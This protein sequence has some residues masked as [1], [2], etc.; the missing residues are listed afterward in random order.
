MKGLL[1]EILY[2]S[3]IHLLQILF[4]HQF[5]ISHNRSLPFLITVVPEISIRRSRPWSISSVQCD[6]TFLS[7]PFFPRRLGYCYKMR[8]IKDIKRA[9]AAAYL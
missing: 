1:H 7:F 2:T 9:C 5:H 3:Y 6:F 8:I 4:Y